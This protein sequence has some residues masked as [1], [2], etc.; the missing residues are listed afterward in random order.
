MA[1]I[2]LK[3]TTTLIDFWSGDTDTRCKR[4]SNGRLYSGRLIGLITD[5]EFAVLIRNKELQKKCLTSATMP[6][7]EIVD[8]HAELE[9]YRMVLAIR[10]INSEPEFGQKLFITERLALVSYLTVKKSAGITGEN[11][12]YMLVDEKETVKNEA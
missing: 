8:N 1:D 7:P 5:R 12:A 6:L 10:E 2:K 11:G 3:R 9:G 4:G